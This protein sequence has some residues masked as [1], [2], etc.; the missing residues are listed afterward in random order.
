MENFFRSVPDK[1]YNEDIFTIVTTG[2]AMRQKNPALFNQIASAFTDN[3]QI[4]FIWIGDGNERE[5]LIITQY[6]NNRLG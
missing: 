4:Q 5:F 3:A 2:R 6:K 1:K